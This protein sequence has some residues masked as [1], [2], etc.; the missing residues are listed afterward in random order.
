MSRRLRTR[1]VLAFGGFAVGVAAILG[2]STAAFLYGA[3]DRF[4]NEQLSEEARHVERARLRDGRWGVPR[5]G[6][7]RVHG[8]PGTMPADLRG[9][10]T[11]EPWRTEFRGAQ[12]R[13][14]H[15]RALGTPRPTGARPSAWLVAEVSDRLVVRP[16]RG[17]LLARWLVAQLA[18]LLL[19][20]G[21]AL[22]IARRISRPLSSLADA[23][24]HL[25]PAG[26]SRPIAIDGADDEVAVVARSLEEMRT[27][28]Q[29]FV[30][31]EQAF[32]QD[33]SHELRTPLSVIR[34]ATSHALADPRIA[35]GS[36]RLLVLALHSAEH[37]ERTVAGLLALAREPALDAPAAS[38]RIVPVL[39]AVVLEQSAAL[40]GHE[41][42]VSIEVPR[43]ATIAAPE[44]VLR[45]LLSNV[46]ANAF[47]HAA[48]GTVRVWVSEGRLTV[49]NPLVP[50]STPAVETLA[51]RGVKREE[52]P[53]FGLGLA[54]VRRL[55]ERSGLPLQWQVSAGGEFEVALGAVSSPA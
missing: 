38:C 37:M 10:L 48:P 13:H 46:I 49:S 8:T 36:R 32:T 41:V 31:R 3:E 51:T 9:P 55:C 14:Y 4:F 22:W 30:C 45:I 16:M 12:G 39:E 42:S 50:G 43:T 44:A 1:I 26:P 29:A 33:A 54:I 2:L 40:D 23:V 47:A 25:D 20:T 5:Q 6:Y 7:M 52:S 15:V 34:T 11:A 28:V 27:R 17:D 24:R 19:A 21:I 53:G 18:I 35:P